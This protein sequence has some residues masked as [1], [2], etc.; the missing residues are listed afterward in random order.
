MNKIFAL[1]IFVMTLCGSLYAADIGIGYNNQAPSI[2]V[3]WN[4]S[5]G[6]ELNISFN[7]SK[8]SEPYPPASTNYNLIYTVTPL[9]WSF[10]RNQYGSL[11]IAARF[12]NYLVFRQTSSYTSLMANDYAV[13][14]ALPEMEINVP[15]VKDLRIT[16]SLGL[17]FSWY[18]NDYTGK[19]SSYNLSFTGMSLANFG[20][21]YYFSAGSDTPAAAPAVKVEQPDPKEVT[22]TAK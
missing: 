9:I 13:L 1:I 7:Y 6:S 20:I 3:W 17:N 15:Y 4:E 8:Q 16:G 5:F 22:N 12:R 10:Y 2:K 21:F 14:L 18:N 11:S 19:L